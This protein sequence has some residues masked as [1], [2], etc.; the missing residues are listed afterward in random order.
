[1]GYSPW[2]YKR[3][4]HYLATKQLAPLLLAKNVMLLYPN[5]IAHSRPTVKNEKLKTAGQHL[6]C[7][8]I[9]RI[10]PLLGVFK[11]KVQFDGYEEAFKRFNSSI[12]GRKN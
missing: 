6:I 12:I 3:V 2:G 10:I 7:Y 1:M 5:E 4:G 11:K 9:L 8:M